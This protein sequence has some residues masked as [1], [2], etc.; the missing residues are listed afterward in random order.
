MTESMEAE[1]TTQ[2]HF[3]GVIA[4]LNASFDRVPRS[5]IEAIRLHEKE[6]IPRL[7][8]LLDDAT[9][10]IRSGRNVDTN[11]H[12]FALFLL[13][14]FRAR[15]ALPA[16][17]RAISTP[18]EGP[19]RLFGDAVTE[20]LAGILAA[21]SGR[22]DLDSFLQLSQNREINEYVRR[23]ALYRLVSM[24]SEGT[25]TRDEAVEILRRSLREAIDK[26]DADLISAFVDALH[27]LYPQEAYQEIKECYEKGL[28]EPFM[29]A[30]EDIDDT[31][32]EDRTEYL[33]RSAERWRPVD[34]TV[35]ELSRWA[36]FSETRDKSRPAARPFDLSPEPSSAQPRGPRLEPLP[37]PEE[38]VGRNDPCPC[39]SG[40]KFK[41]CCM[42]R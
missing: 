23:A 41:K 30:L 38:R 2:S 27:E 42:P 10:A 28:M 35:K 21:L 7:I 1:S 39:G 25:Y 19:F 20:Q 13:A 33:K 6:M 37:S 8:G 36:S 17:L 31:L 5:A 9:R 40:K 12:F 22:E 4:E 34:D 26:E 18:G 24:V 32:R 3:D 16:V 11:G 14:E 29:M 15:E